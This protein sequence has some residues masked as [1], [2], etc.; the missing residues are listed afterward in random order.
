MLERKEFHS[1]DRIGNSCV[2][3][4]YEA[5]SFCGTQSPPLLGQLSALLAFSSKS[6]FHQYGEGKVLRIREIGKRVA[7]PLNSVAC[8]CG[9]RPL[10]PSLFFCNESPVPLSA[11]SG[12]CS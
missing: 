6:V 5:A 11:I 7:V 4:G 2:L 1:M 10:A 12:L 9:S 8:P 3:L